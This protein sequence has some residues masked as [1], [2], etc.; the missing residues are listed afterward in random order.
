M[1][2]TPK[3]RDF[4]ALHGYSHNVNGLK[5]DDKLERLADSIAAKGIT[6][7]C[8][9][10]TWL[11]GDN[12]YQVETLADNKPAFCLVFHHGQPNQ[13]GRGLGGVAIILGPKGKEALRLA[14]SPDPIYAPPH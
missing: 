10:E 5:Q 2:R 3:P 11:G 6:F 4:T 9:Q 12:L 8:L 14:G 1:T 7:C 13:R